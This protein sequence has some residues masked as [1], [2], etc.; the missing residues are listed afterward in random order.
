MRSRRSAHFASPKT[1]KRI[2][3]RYVENILSLLACQCSRTPLRGPRRREER[4][5][6]K[7][8]TQTGQHRSPAASE[9]AYG[10]R[11]AARCARRHRYLSRLGSFC[12][13]RSHSRRVAANKSAAAEERENDSS[14]RA[15]IREWRSF[16]S[17]SRSRSVAR[18]RRHWRAACCHLSV[19]AV[20]LSRATWSRSVR[21]ARHRPML[22]HW[23]GGGVP[24]IAE[25]TSR[26]CAPDP[27]AHDRYAVDCC[28]SIRAATLMSLREKG[29]WVR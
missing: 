18:N 10:A 9:A 26:A 11:P 14:V 17:I 25:A 6:S 19:A 12:K 16:I 24:K 27:T 20:R 3:I 15:A 22:S 2:N 1:R 13:R 23:K 29:I 5:E 28:T 21:W 7:T 4:T 8:N